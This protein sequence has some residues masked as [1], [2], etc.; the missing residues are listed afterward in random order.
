MIALS[1]FKE[2]VDIDIEFSGLK[3]GEKLYEEVQHFDE[4]H[5]ETE[6]PRIF[7]FIADNQAQVPLKVIESA[8]IS[9]MHT[10]DSASIKMAIQKLVEEYSPSPSI[11]D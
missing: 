2:N 5:R 7:K 9:S 6:H 4:V 11:D 8:L 1:G 3:A 10:H